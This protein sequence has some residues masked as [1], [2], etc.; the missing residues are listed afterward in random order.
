MLQ[1]LGLAK[2]LGVALEFCVN[3]KRRC[4]LFWGYLLLEIAQSFGKLASTT[5][6]YAGEGELLEADAETLVQ[7]I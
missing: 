3:H 4:L 5:F 7:G 2:F 1:L 6:N